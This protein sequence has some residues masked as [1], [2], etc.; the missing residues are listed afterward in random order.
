MLFAPLLQT[1]DTSGYMIAGYVIFIVL[2][3]LFI[4][5]L[6]Y[7]QRNLKRDKETMESLM[8]DEQRK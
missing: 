5:S 2:P 7:R 3:I 8:Q 4:A 6:I 1:P